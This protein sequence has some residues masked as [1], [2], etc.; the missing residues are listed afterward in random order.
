MADTDQLKNCLWESAKE[1]FDTM[2]HLPLE[3]SEDQDTQIQQE[4]L[5]LGSITFK[6]HIEGALVI[7]CDMNC[8]AKVAR[9]MLMMGQDEDIDDSGVHDAL[10]ELA[11]LVVGTVKSKMKKPLD[12]IKVSI[13]TVIRGSRLQPTIGLRAIRISCL[14]AGLRLPGLKR[15]I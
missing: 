5:L 12:D 9:S 3:Q 10:G 4:N 13:P 7:Q 6:G 8:A 15:P 2:V 11:N 1:V 14:R